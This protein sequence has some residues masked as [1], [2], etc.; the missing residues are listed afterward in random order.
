MQSLPSERYTPYLVDGEY[1]FVTDDKRTYA[2][3]FVE[4]PFFSED[5]YA[6][7]E[8]TYEVFLRLEKAPPAYATDPKVGATVTA[9]VKDF[10]SKD[11]QRVVFF[12]CDTSDGR[13]FARF[14][15]FS[16]WFTEF[17]D[18]NFGRYD[19]RIRNPRTNKL[20]LIMMLVHKLHPNRAD[21]IVSYFTLTAQLRDQK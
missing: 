21:V 16:Y 14:R 8:I 12:T 15:K 2:V 13:Q 9:I 3:S 19:E 18:G 20:Y 17:E 7:A 4:Q 6:Y 11:Y 10:V 1:V 5:D